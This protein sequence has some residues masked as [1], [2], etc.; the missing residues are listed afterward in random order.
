M[1]MNFCYYCVIFVS[2]IVETESTTVK[3][4]NLTFCQNDEEVVAGI[5]LVS[6]NDPSSLI[7]G[8]NHC[9]NSG[10]HCNAVLDICVSPVPSKYVYV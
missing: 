1:N 3:P 8:R 5:Q 7:V 6:Y 10:T 4:T 9:D 2:C